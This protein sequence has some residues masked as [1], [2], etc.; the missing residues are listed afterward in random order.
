MGGTI[1]RNQ[2]NISTYFEIESNDEKHNVFRSS[3]RAPY[4]TSTTITFKFTYFCIRAQIVGGF[5]CVFTFSETAKA[6]YDSAHAGEKGYDC[7]IYVE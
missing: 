6:K 5:R 7:D 3:E 1:N 4:A 2:W